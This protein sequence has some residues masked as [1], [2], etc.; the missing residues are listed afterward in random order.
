MRRLRLAAGS[1]TPEQSAASSEPGVRELRLS[2]SFL[3][4]KVGMER[5]QT[6]SESSGFG[7][8]LR[9]VPWLP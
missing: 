3:V 2:L 8:V 9:E 5:G 4:R 7:E 1:E 6:R